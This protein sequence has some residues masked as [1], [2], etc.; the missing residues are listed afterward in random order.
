M[1]ELHIYLEPLAGKEKELEDLY[2]N[3]Y[4]PGISIQKGFIR[5][6]LLKNRN[7][8]RE[9]EI[10]ITFE[11]EELRL[12]WVKS[13]EHQEVWPKVVLLCA[14]ISWRGFDTVEKT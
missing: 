13:K 5:T 2:W 14:R 10:H 3:D 9:Y 6:T 8:L 1:I 4:V 7:A 12:D 11:S